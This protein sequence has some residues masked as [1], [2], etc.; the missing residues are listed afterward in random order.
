MNI[1]FRKQFLKELFFSS[2]IVA[3]LHLLALI[4]HLYWTIDWYDIPMHFL[5]GFTIGI[6]AVFIFFTSLYI[7]STSKLKD[8]RVILFMFT[9]GF[10]LIVGLAWE[11]WEL[12][13]RLTDVFTDQLDTVVDLVMDFCGS[14]TAFLYVNKRIK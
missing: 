9:I 7:P 4:Y 6:L 5:G 12:F 1:I 14:V 13:F 11:V 2:V 3:C 8:N 10:T